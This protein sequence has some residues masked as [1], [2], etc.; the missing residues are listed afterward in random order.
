MADR[1]ED[2]TTVT[3]IPVKMQPLRCHVQWQ[4]LWEIHCYRSRLQSTHPLCKTSWSPGGG[5]LEV[6]PKM[7]INNNIVSS[8][9]CII[10]FIGYIKRNICSCILGSYLWLL[11]HLSC[12]LIL[13]FPILLVLFFIFEI[14]SQFE[15]PVKFLNLHS[16]KMRAL[17]GDC[18][19]SLY[20][21]V[22]N[23]S[24]FPSIPTTPNQLCK[25]PWS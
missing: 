23:W 21:Y 5:I 24:L 17:V 12:P 6:F 14:D 11:F 2:V 22:V 1:R 13:W 9:Q 15:F 3:R 25:A 4:F 18:A 7:N 16:T 10:L 19:C 20:L 8:M